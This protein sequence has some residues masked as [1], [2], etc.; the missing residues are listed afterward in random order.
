MDKRVYFLMVISFVIGMVELIISGILDLIAEDLQVS[1][2]QVGLLITVFALIMAIASP[3]LLVITAKVERKKLTLICLY[4]FLIGCII[5]V[6]SPNFTILFIARI[7]LAL[8]GALLIILCLVMA[9]SL[10]EEKYRGRAIGFVSMGV[11][12]SLVLGVPI[13]LLLGN[14]FGWRAPFILITGLTALS[15]IGVHFFMDSIQPKTQ[16]PLKVQLASL[17]SPKIT[18]A[19]MTTFL[20]MSGHT[21]IYAYFSPYIQTTTDLDGGWVSIVYLIFGVAAVSGGGIGGVLADLF[22]SKRSI[23]LALILFSFVF[24]ILPF[25]T[26]IFPMLFLT[27]IIWGILSW[28]ISPA[29]QTYL[30]ETSPKTSDIQQSLN[31]S[32]LHLGVAVGSI[33]GGMVVEELSIEHNPFVGGILI[34]LSLFTIVISFKSR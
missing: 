29:M 5:T 28:A 34:I 8:S 13:G 12:A 30:I 27:L 6:L 4:I 7:I 32:A 9:P 23:L 15:I 20:Y 10:V 3:I 16:V 25:T 14:A 21:V 17:K 2:A 22:G 33:I 1:L 26:E 18:F 19:I 31:N 11:S 24:F